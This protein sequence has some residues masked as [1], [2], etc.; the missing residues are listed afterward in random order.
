MCFSKRRKGVT[1]RKVKTGSNGTKFFYGRT[2]M[3]LNDGCAEQHKEQEFFFCVVLSCASYYRN[4]TCWVILRRDW[5][6]HKML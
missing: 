2:W 1:G 3:H 5:I 6:V 4:R